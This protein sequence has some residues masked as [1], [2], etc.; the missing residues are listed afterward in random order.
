MSGAE[1][2]I[3]L[4]VAS[5]GSQVVG[6]IMSSKSKADAAKQDAALKNM[7]ADELISRET[8]NEQIIQ[9]Q[10]D[11][12]Q[13]E[14]GAA[15]A[16]TGREGAG[17]G[18]I[19]QIRKTTA[20]TIANDQRDAQFKAMMLRSGANIANSLASDEIASGYVTGAGTLLSGGAKLAS[21]FR[22]ASSSTESLPTTGAD[23][24]SSGN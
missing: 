24:T 19:L 3:A 6:S 2:P 14:F 12:Q 4:T 10:S 16:S 17:I 7:Q 18:G 21:A 13:R 1:I 8:V 23:T 15:F 20:Q 9:E 5:I 11:I 22:K